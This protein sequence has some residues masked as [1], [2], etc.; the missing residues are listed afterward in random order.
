MIFISQTPSDDN[1]NYIITWK[2]KSDN[3]V[4]TEH[5]LFSI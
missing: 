1:G 2:D 4:T 3:I 5:N